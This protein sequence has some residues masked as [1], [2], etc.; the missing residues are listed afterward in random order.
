MAAPKAKPLVKQKKKKDTPVGVKKEASVPD[1]DKKLTKHG[2][3][4]VASL[5]AKPQ[6]KKKEENLTIP[7]VPPASDVTYND[8]KRKGAPPPA[9]TSIIRKRPL[10]SGPPAKRTRRVSAHEI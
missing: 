9:R 10:E 3:K 8:K 5:G 2:P 4:P 1:R 7:H 6:H